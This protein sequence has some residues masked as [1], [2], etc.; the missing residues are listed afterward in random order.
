MLPLLAKIHFAV[1]LELPLF[2]PAQRNKGKAN[3]I[4]GIEIKT[5]KTSDSK[6]QPLLELEAPLINIRNFM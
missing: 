4:L 3:S 2:V 6:N 1:Y 5:E